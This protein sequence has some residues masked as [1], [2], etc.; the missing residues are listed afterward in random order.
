MLTKNPNLFEKLTNKNI[1][2]KEKLKNKKYNKFNKSNK[3]NKFNINYKIG[4]NYKNKFFYNKKRI[5][6]INKKLLVSYK[7]L[8]LFYNKVRNHYF[9]YDEKN[10]STF[11]KN[12]NN[13]IDKKKRIS[14]KF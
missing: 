2:F 4:K 3:F 13:L 1:N 7:L 10:E 14:I 9:Y 6:K 5:N 8:K 11:R 12:I